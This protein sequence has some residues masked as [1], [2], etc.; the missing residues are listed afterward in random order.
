MTIIYSLAVLPIRVQNRCLP[1]VGRLPGVQ[2]AR[3]VVPADFLNRKGLIASAAFHFLYPRPMEPDQVT[4]LDVCGF[5][6]QC[7]GLRIAFSMNLKTIL[8]TENTAL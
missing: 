6:S 3:S 8:V 4:H 1:G 5:S 7:I 2:H